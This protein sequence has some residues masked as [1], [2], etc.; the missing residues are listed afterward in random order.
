[1]LIE[2]DSTKGGDSEIP[3]LG[4]VAAVFTT[5]SSISDETRIQRLTDVEARQGGSLR[6]V[7]VQERRIVPPA[8]KLVWPVWDEFY[9]AADL[10]LP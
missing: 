7:E 5:I 2:M 1:M 10:L 4:D 6:D 8:E 3:W 9:A